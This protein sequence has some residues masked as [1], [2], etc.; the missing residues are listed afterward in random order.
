MPL[1]RIRIAKD[2]QMHRRLPKTGKFQLCIGLPARALA[3]V[4]GK[5]VSVCRLE[6]IC[7]RF[8]AVL[9]ANANDTPRLAVSNRGGKVRKA[10]KPVNKPFVDGPREKPP[11]IPPP[12][13]KRFKFLLKFRIKLR[14]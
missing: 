13:Q 4:S 12:A 3:A 5:R 2:S 14:R 10:E 7:D 9:G 8:P 6:G 11:H 1:R